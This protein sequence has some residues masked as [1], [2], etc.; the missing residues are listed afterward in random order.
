MLSCP[1]SLT[2]SL[3]RECERARA[4]AY[5]HTRTH[6]HTQAR[7]HANTDVHVHNCREM[8]LQR[9]SFYVC[10]SPVGTLENSFQCRFS[11]MPGRLYT[12]TVDRWKLSPDRFSWNRCP[13]I[14][15]P[16]ATWKTTCYALLVV[17]SFS[18][19]RIFVEF[20][21]V[22]ISL[23][24]SLSLSLLFAITA[25]FRSSY[26]CIEFSLS[27]F[28]FFF[29][30]FFFD[31]RIWT[32]RFAAISYIQDYN[33]HHKIS[34]NTFW[35]SQSRYVNLPSTYCFLDSF[36]RWKLIHTF[37]WKENEK[38]RLTYYHKMIKVEHIKFR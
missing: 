12:I 22:S 36:Q 31:W 33:W 26:F 17:L 25:I 4:R 6:A 11:E 7:T 2:P 3:G 18:P 29:F 24:L 1:H 27:L 34:K 8:V 38:E 35:V 32:N 10:T 5:T 15:P 13:I 20:S 37:P 14:L 23:S 21:C 28:L 16:R 30:F 9:N 19:D